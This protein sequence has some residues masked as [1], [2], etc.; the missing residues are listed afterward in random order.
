[1]IMTMNTAVKRISLTLIALCLAW[2]GLQQFDFYSA[3]AAMALV[4]SRDAE[5]GPQ[6]K[7]LSREEA[8]QRQPSSERN[9]TLEKQINL[10]PQKAFCDLKKK[11]EV[12]LNGELRIRTLPTDDGGRMIYIYSS[13]CPRDHYSLVK[14]LPSGEAK[15]IS[16]CRKNSTTELALQG[17]MQS[18]VLDLPPEEGEL[19]LALSGPGLFLAWCD[20]G[21]R[22]VRQGKFQI[23]EDG[24]VT[25]EEGCFVWSRPNELGSTGEPLFLDP[26]DKE[27]FFDGCT[28]GNR[29]L[30][31]LDPTKI[32]PQGPELIGSQEFAL[33]QFSL[34]NLFQQLNTTEF[35]Y[36]FENALEDLNNPDLSIT[37]AEKIDLW[38]AIPSALDCSKL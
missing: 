23:S 24:M 20:E 21:F 15:T 8:P 29:C 14:I 22:A 31:I 34:K 37:G 35:T 18:P 6:N 32:G 17:S 27:I 25:T 30:A 26:E 36:V 1:M 16:D 10:D 38:E 11:S 13:E 2:W 4:T 12:P 9:Q 7:I 19:N 3:P 33:N 28:K 5:K